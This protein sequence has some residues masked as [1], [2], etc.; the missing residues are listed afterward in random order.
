MRMRSLL[1]P[2]LLALCF[3]PVSGFAETSYYVD[4][5]DSYFLSPELACKS[6]TFSPVTSNG[7]TYSVTS[8]TVV[9]AFSYHGDYLT[10]PLRLYDKDGY[11]I[12]RAGEVGGTLAKITFKQCVVD[13]IN[14]LTWPRYQEDS[15]GATIPGTEVPIF[16]NPVCMN[17]CKAE[18]ISAVDDCFYD[19]VNFLFC[20]FP[21]KGTGSACSVPTVAPDTPTGCPS[22]YEIVGGKC[23]LIPPVDPCIA[24]P[25]GA[26]CPGGDTGGN[27][28][29]DTGGDT[30][31]NTGGDTGGDTGGNTGGDTGGDTGGNTGG[32]TGGD[33]GG[34]SGLG[35]NE[36]FVCTGD[37]VQCVQASFEKQQLCDLKSGNDYSND[38]GRGFL[39][40]HMEQN[41]TNEMEET[42]VHLT[43]ILTGPGTARFLPSSCPAAQTF[44]VY[45][46]QFAFKNDYFCNFATSMSWLVVAMASLFAAVYI[47]NSFKG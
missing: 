37:S 30:G 22:G 38:A 14:I 28:G 8:A 4:V 17:G 40:S 13:E 29:G 44:T 24:E 39:E 11:Y 35:C 43:S 42:E 25:T 12:D 32:D 26:G 46:R 41:K 5:T 21:V 19:G 27:T 1:L 2:L 20:N 47:G 3:F 7:S 34:A 16:S 31:G 18:H 15:L 45:G 10:C 33:T 23:K 9:G 6:L 36:A